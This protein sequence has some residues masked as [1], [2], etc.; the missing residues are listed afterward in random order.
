MRGIVQ[1]RELGSVFASSAK[2]S[3]SPN[4]RARKG[5]EGGGGRAVGRSVCLGSAKV[6]RGGA[7]RGRGLQAGWQEGW[8]GGR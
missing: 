6:A 1:L 5:V 4:A 8:S 7:G 2:G 3:I